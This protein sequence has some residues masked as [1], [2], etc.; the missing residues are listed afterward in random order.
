MFKA[1]GNAIIEVGT[2]KQ[3]AVVLPSNCTKNLAAKIAAF[4]AERMNQEMVATTERGATRRKGAQASATTVPSSTP[5][6]Q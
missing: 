5:E 1:R 2:G 6:K 4:A 3:I